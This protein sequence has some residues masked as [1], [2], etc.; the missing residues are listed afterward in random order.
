MK[1]RLTR[2]GFTLV[3][4]LV[5]IAIIGILVAL[6]LPALGTVRES[7]RRSTCTANQKQMALALKSCEEQRRSMPAAAWYRSTNDGEVFCNP[8]AGYVGTTMIG[9]KG[10]V[11]TNQ[12]DVS[13]D[14]AP[15]SFIVSLLPYLENSHVYDKIDFSKTAFDDQDGTE[16]DA[17]TGAVFANEDLWTEKIMALTCPSYSDSQVSGATTAEYTTADAIPA[18]TNYK[19]V[20]ATDKITLNSGALCTASSIVGGAGSDKGD[21]GGMLNPYG[22]T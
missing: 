13:N 10:T 20:G 12:A 9:K 4:L 15:Y 18:I 6:L 22:K 2:R 14:T 8:T 11:P 1:T 21:G 7:A 3:E 16:T 19:G 17:V 5:V